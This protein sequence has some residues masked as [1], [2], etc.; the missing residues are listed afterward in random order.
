MMRNLEKDMD[1]ILITGPTASGKS[2]LAVKLARKH[3]G[4][5]I[6]ADSMQVYDTL[7]V[8]TARPD[9]AE[10]GGIE[11]LLFGH[12][13]AGAPYSTGAWLREAEAVVTR[14]REE[15]RLPVFV[16]GTGLY[17]KALTGGLSNMPEIPSAIRD[18]LRARLKEEGP[19]PLHAELALR[20]PET[21]AELR[22]GDGQRIVR[23]LE[24]I[25]ATGKPIGFYRE[26]R[27]P[28]V[29]D[30]ER[31]QKIVVQPE[32]A[33]LHRR[34]ERRFETMLASGAVEEVRALLALNLSPDMPVMKAIGVQQIAAMLKGEMSEAEMIAAGA[35]ATRQYAKRQ[36]T[37]FR[38]QLDESW[39][40]VENP[41]AVA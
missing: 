7:K 29:V 22:P 8:L 36:M 30:P 17:F 9:E 19:E 13:P 24:V 11:H 1:A 10:M 32:R 39:Q 28:V 14:L 21:A 23:A 31:A 20:D 16:G 18:R 38:N 2:A 34:I 27:G 6:N 12:V 40:R 35:A 15:G 26:S 25:E 37:W 41:D 3:G 5:V 33:L 4:V